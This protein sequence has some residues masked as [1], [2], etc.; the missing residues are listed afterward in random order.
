MIKRETLK[1]TLQI[2]ASVI[3]AVLTALGATSCMGCNPAFL[4]PFGSKRQSRAIA[5]P[6]QGALNVYGDVVNDMHLKASALILHQANRTS[7][8]GALFI[9]YNK[10]NEPN[11]GPV[12]VA[13]VAKAKINSV[14]F[15]F[16]LAYSY[17]RSR[18]I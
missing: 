10:F 16:F 14:F 17:L 1:W 4:R 8:S 13:K 6:W 9:I 7:Y 3:T 5:A 11:F 15:G 12:A 18:I 2:I